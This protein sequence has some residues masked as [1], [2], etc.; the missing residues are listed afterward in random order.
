MLYKLSK[1]KF[2]ILCLVASQRC[3]QQ[4]ASILNVQENSVELKIQALISVFSLNSKDELV[5]FFDKNKDLILI[6]GDR[7]SSNLIVELY[8]MGLP[9]IQIIKIISFDKHYVRQV[10]KQHEEIKKQIIFTNM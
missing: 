6:K 3:S 5:S 7:K 1:R 10:I 2:E 9:P 4:I 8:Y